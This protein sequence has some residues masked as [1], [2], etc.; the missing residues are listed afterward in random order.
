M[1]SWNLDPIENALRRSAVEP[2]T[3]P[4]L[5]ET[6]S[7]VVGG[8]GALLFCV[9]RRA[10]GPIAS[11]S[12]AEMLNDYLRL[13]WHQH[14]ARYRGIPTMERRGVATDDDCLSPQEMK[15][16]P[17]YQDFLRKRGHFWF[18]GVGFR[19]GEDLWCLSIQRTIA[20]GPFQRAETEALKTLWRPF[21]DAA[22]LSRQID[23]SH[24]EGCAKGLEAVGHAALVCDKT[25]HILALNGQAEQ[26]IGT[27]ISARHGWRFRDPRSAEAFDRLIGAAG[28]AEL[29]ASAS[30]NA[31]T[32]L[33]AV[34]QRLVV[35]AIPLRDVGPFLGTIGAILLLVARERP[36]PAV[37]F[38]KSYGLTEAEFAIA[39]ALA[40]G[41]SV[42]AI[43]AIRSVRRATVRAQLKT[44]YAKT[45]THSQ[46]QLVA[47]LA[48]V[49]QPGA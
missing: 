44:I 23:R 20:Q 36:A 49:E 5:L 11:P 3:W 13:G 47:L 26:L 28:R 45:C 22:T 27:M 30:P 39:K 40:G 38:R 25:G 17:F 12:Q 21:S 19:A 10:A 7:Q 35:R 2:E 14:D 48:R 31:T 43:A 9:D 46:A 24:V 32:L 42:E 41:S 18:A 16:S 34:G 37:V 4:A 6:V 1:T 15:V 8:A 29:T 33:D